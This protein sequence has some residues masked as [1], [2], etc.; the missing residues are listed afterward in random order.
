M[1][2]IKFGIIGCGLMGKEFASAVARWCHLQNLNAKPEIV[3]VCDKND[4]LFSWYKDNI[5]SVSQFSTDY[6]DLLNNKEVEAIYCAVPHFMHEKI[7]I[8]IISHGKHLLG[9]KPFGMDFQQNQKIMQAI[10]NN[11]G[12]LIRSSSEF[13]F[14][15]GAQRLVA[16]AEANAFGTILE[17]NAG[18]LHSS[19]LDPNKIINWKRQNEYNGEYGCMGDLGMHVFHLPLRLGWMPHTVFASLSKIVS[20]RPDS[21]GKTVPCD[22][23]DNALL[24]CQVKD[25]DGHSFPMITKMYRIAPGETDTWYLEIKGTKACGSFS[26]KNPKTF[27]SMFYESGGKQETRYEDLGYAS[28]Y[29]SITGA[30]F[31]FGFTDA[32]LQMWG[33]FVDELA[34][35]KTNKFICATPEETMMSHKIFTAAL[36][37][38]KERKAVHLI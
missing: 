8:D 27:V 24:H 5:P 21:S 30:I 22:T 33:A 17:V 25:K 11:P 12:K 14:F 3:A 7:Y 26:T 9:E 34:N 28:L 20:Q 16:M 1:R 19:D 37:S 38:Q 2:V 23:W 32:I 10:A 18:F 31:E 13:P 4:S 15:P 36:T 29:P 35:G 6:Q